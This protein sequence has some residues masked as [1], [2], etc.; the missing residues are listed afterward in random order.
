MYNI[1]QKLMCLLTAVLLSMLLC[2]PAMATST[3]YDSAHSEN[4]NMADLQATA[5]I[6]IEKNTGMVV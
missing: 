1:K 6:L 5:A 3:D 2:V 4:L